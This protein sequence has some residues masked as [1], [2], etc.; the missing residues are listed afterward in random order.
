MTDQ[1]VIPTLLEMVAGCQDEEIKRQCANPVS[2]LSMDVSC[3]EK[4]VAQGAVAAIVE[5]SLYKNPDDPKSVETDRVCASALNVLSSDGD[6]S[7]RLIREG[8]IPAL[9][10]LISREDKQVKTECAHCL[11]I[12][13]QYENGINE[14][15]DNGAVTALI[16]LA[17][18]NE[19]STSGNCALALYNLLSHENASR[20]SGQGILNALVDLSHSNDLSTKTTCAAALWELTTLKNSDPPKLIPALIKMLRDE[21]DSQIKGDCAAALYNLAQD[22]ENCQIMMDNNCLEPLLSLVDSENFGTRVQCGAI[23]SRLSFNEENRLQMANEVFVNALFKLAES[24][25]PSAGY[26][27][28]SLMTQQRIVNAIYNVSSHPSARPLFLARGAATFLTNFQTRPLEAIRKGC[29]ASLCNLLA[30]KGTELDVLNVGGVSALLITALVASD[31]FETKKIC[32]KCLYNLLSEPA[33]HDT[34]V[35]EGVLWGFAA[36]CKG[37]DG[38]IVPDLEMSRMCSQAF[39]NLTGQYAKEILGSTACVKILFLLTGSEDHPTK[40]YSSRALLNILSQLSEGDAEEEMIACQAAKPLYN[41]CATKD[42][43]V[44]GL[45]LLGFCMISKFKAAR[46]E[47]TAMEAIKAVEFDIVLDDPELSYTYAATISNLLLE[48]VSEQIIGGSVARNLMLLSRSKEF[49]TVMVVARAIYLCTCEVEFISEIVKIGG[50]E[51]VQELFL[52]EEGDEGVSDDQ[53]SELHSFLAI[54][55]FNMSTASDCHL[56]IVNK[57]AIQLIR[58]L[59][60]SGNKNGDSELTRI[61]ALTAAN[62][63]CGQVNSAKIVG[64]QVRCNEPLASR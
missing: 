35:K 37:P 18:P 60:E 9:L 54:S 64:Q 8:A 30:D 10:A 24:E 59:W 47:L 50:V 1:R 41:M 44:Q 46:E 16:N 26:T 52:I 7:E 15:I 43:S 28:D 19:P 33:C 63:S 6:S 12:L 36:L 2:R 40:L 49:R 51:A 27:N 4:V 20:V 13:F 32:T 55:L 22:V 58:V 25:P 21:E 14:M 39:C 29:A 31:K 56:D 17:D 57:D 23:L 11:C 42:P 38:D 45:C 61:C 3:R 48:G 62:L 5:M 53:K 34:M